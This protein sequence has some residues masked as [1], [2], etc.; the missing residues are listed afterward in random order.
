MKMQI[1]QSRGLKNKA[2]RYLGI[3]TQWGKWGIEALSSPGLITAVP[4]ITMMIVVLGPSLATTLLHLITFVVLMYLR[5][6]WVAAAMREVF[7]KA[8]TIEDENERQKLLERFNEV[9][10]PYMQQVALT[11]TAFVICTLII[12]PHIQRSLGIIT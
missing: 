7:V 8:A 9:K 1:Q 5:D 12:M 4:I 6:S 3:D 10:S 2:F 11:M